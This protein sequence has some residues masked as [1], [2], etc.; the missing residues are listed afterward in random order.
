MA[1]L[2]PQPILPHGP[3]GLAG[4]PS[5]EV[6]AEALVALHGKAATLALL[7]R[8]APEPIEIGGELGAVIARAEPWQRRLVAQTIADCDAML[9]TGLAA[10]GTLSRRG[11]DTAAPA[12][13]LWREF[14]MARTGM[15]AVLQSE[16]SAPE[17]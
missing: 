10:L 1:S 8:L 2:P 9:D 7:A 6:L 14:H 12:L 13:A 11:Q 4:D 5:P 16:A 3:A 17:G 15:I